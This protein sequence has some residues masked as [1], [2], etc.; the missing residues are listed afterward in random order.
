M[1]SEAA[2]EHHVVF[3]RH[4]ESVGNAEERFQGQADFPLSENGRGQAA[5]LAR[6]WQQEGAAFDRAISS[7][8]LRARETA[9]IVCTAL[10]VPLEFDPGWMEIDNGLLAGLNGEE[11]AHR[12]PRPAFMTPYDHFGQT[13]ESRW[14]LYLRAGGCIQK[15]LDR[16]AGRYLVVSHGGILGMAMYAMLSIAPQADYHGPRFVFEN[17]TF[18]TLVYQPAHHNWRMLAFDGR[19]H[20]DPEG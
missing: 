11:A 16:P 2:R 14:E 6:R 17:T 19:A 15:L 4:G 8:L 1:S 7:P 12:L 13:G 5:A 9:E 3:L 10:E 18:A 20:W